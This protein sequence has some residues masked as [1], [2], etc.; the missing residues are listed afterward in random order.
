[1]TDE[2]GSWFVRAFAAVADDAKL[3]QLPIAQFMQAVN[4][5]IQDFGGMYQGS[6][7][8]MVASPTNRLDK[9]YYLFPPISILD[10]FISEPLLPLMLEIDCSI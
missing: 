1:M 9:D 10:S 5:K 2:D 6:V 8:S 7:V 4:S 3:K